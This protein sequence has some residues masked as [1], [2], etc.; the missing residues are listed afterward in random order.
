MHLWSANRWGARV[1]RGDDDRWI[2]FDKPYAL[3]GSHPRCDI[4]IEGS[5]LPEV[6]YLIVACGDRIEAWPTC[7]IAFPIWGR[8]HKA[9]VLLV[10]KSRIQ[11]CLECEF[12]VASQ[13]P[14]D[15]PI[16]MGLET[17]PSRDSVP[18]PTAGL[19][20]DW[21]SGPK[22]KTLNRNVSIL[23][24][25]H[26]SLIRLH[27]ANL[28]RCDHG[29]ICFGEDLWL[30]NLHPSRVRD[31][32]P[33]LRHVPPTE[34]SLCI[35][36]VHLW[37]ESSPP[38]N[39]ER[40]TR[41]PQQRN[42]LGIRPSFMSDLDEEPS[43]DGE[44]PSMEDA[45]ETEEGQK[46]SQIGA[47]RTVHQGHDSEEMEKL[48]QQLSDRVLETSVRKSVRQRVLHGSMI[49]TLAVIALMIVL[50]ILLWGVVPII[51]TIYG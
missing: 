46:N 25:D 20:L 9:H 8:I 29:I 35:G 45:A 33:L 13:G 44:R 32:E 6:V 19:I 39:L 12:K 50:L 27:R 48:T 23:G 31:G 30:V 26:P 49:G 34:R 10:G 1:R 3:V 38:V 22:R 37:S 14:N 43:F 21:G 18:P 47:L 4:V 16:K 40:L 15:S 11:F 5:K 2:D 41:S 42:V 24:E 36:G 51:Q 7:P 28:E 17:D